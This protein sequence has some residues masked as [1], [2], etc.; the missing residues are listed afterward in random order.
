MLCVEVKRALRTWTIQGLQVL[1]A[2]VLLALRQTVRYAAQAG[3]QVTGTNYVDR[4]R[5][6]RHLTN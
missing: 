6:G 1:L 5:K 4:A 3:A 2:A